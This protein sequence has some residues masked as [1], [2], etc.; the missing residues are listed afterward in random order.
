MSSGP[1]NAP[2]SVASVAAGPPFL[3]ATLLRPPSRRSGDHGGGGRRPTSGTR[4][5]VHGMEFP[6]GGGEHGA[7]QEL[8]S[9][10]TTPEAT[11]DG[12]ER[13]LRIV[14]PAATRAASFAPPA[15][16]A[17]LPV[18]TST[19]TTDVMA[20]YRLATDERPSAD[21]VPG[22][23]GQSNGRSHGVVRATTSGRQRQSEGH[24]LDTS[25]SGEEDTGKSQRRRDRKAGQGPSAV[26]Q[27][28]SSSSGGEEAPSGFRVD[29][30][31]RGPGNGIG[32]EQRQ[33]GSGLGYDPDAIGG[34]DDSRGDADYG[35]VD[36]HGGNNPGG[37][38]PPTAEELGGVA[39]E[40]EDA[41]RRQE[42][43]L[44]HLTLHRKDIAARWQTSSPPGVL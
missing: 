30:E 39:G 7:H 17:S 26:G 42:E 20:A 16:A 32:P 38:W 41:L 1:R 27:W 4:A 34:H 2:T 29:E 12:N 36:N 23:A 9:D 33:R 40:W 25:S 24:R 19:V 21:Q 35:Y 31:A 8:F 15:G 37:E 13:P 10:C 22:F 14:A 28:D 5:Q 11:E 18:H 3:A 6:G 43:V 44:R